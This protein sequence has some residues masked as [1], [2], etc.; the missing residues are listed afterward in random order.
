MG[1]AVMTKEGRSA[2]MR[3]RHICFPRVDLPE[4]TERDDADESEVAEDED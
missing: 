2:Y 3:G 1:V 4:V